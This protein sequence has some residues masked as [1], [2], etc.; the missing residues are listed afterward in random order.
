[1][2]T[3]WEILFG[4]LLLSPTWSWA[5][6]VSIALMLLF[7]MLAARRLTWSWAIAEL[8][9]IVAIAPQLFT[10]PGLSLL[11]LPPLT[12]VTL[13]V[14]VF[15]WWH[16]R[17]STGDP[18]SPGLRLQR[19]S[20]RTY[21]I[22][23]AILLAATLVVWMPFIVDGGLSIVPA[24]QL[25]VTIVSIFTVGLMIVTLLGFAFGI[26]ESWWLL[27]IESA[28]YLF[29]ALLSLGATAEVDEL[30]GL[31]TPLIM[32][33][34]HAAIIVFAVRGYRAWRAALASIPR[35]PALYNGLL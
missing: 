18:E 19:A 6:P 22:A 4:T 28:L 9:L 20:R 26:L 27:L 33:I 24:A 30:Q 34:L 2:D 32:V 23:A 3:L 35:A 11:Q 31:G 5:S 12:L 1:M 14:P 16:W 8:S 29:S 21:L 7:A 13:L 15:G 25:P 17:R 10:V